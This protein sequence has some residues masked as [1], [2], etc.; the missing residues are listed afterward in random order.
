MKNEGTTL[1]LLIVC[2]VTLISSISRKKSDW[3]KAGC[4]VLVFLVAMTSRSHRDDVM[5]SR[6][7]TA[8]ALRGNYIWQTANGSAERDKNW[9]NL[10]RS[11]ALIR[12]PEIE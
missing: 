12:A 3:K 11:S 6:A 9:S 8:V 10:H 4:H 7:D 1:P 5:T 2:Y